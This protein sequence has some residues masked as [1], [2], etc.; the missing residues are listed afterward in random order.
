MTRV[1]SSPHVRLLKGKEGSISV[2]DEASGI[3]CTALV[4]D[5]SG[6]SEAQTTVS[7][8]E[9]GKIIWSKKETVAMSK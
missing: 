5:A 6:K 7:V 2:G 8:M 1:V 3:T 4:D 9:E